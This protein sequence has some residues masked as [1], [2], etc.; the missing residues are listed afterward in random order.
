MA[1]KLRII[2]GVVGIAFYTVSP[3]PVYSQ[4]YGG[5]G[6]SLQRLEELCRAGALMGATGGSGRNYIDTTLQGRYSM[7][8]ST[9]Q[10]YRN[11]INWFRSSCPAY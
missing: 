10:Q 5:T 1:T 2:S 7:G 11:Q 4:G 3:L 9:S 6:I 8:N